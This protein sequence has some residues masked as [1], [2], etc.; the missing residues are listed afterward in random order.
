MTKLNYGAQKIAWWAHTGHFLSDCDRNTDDN[1]DN[2][3]Y[4]L[5]ASLVGH[6]RSENSIKIL[7]FA[8]WNQSL[9]TRSMDNTLEWL[10]S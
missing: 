10:N 8:L 9:N 6:N 4:K 2:K 7:D 1:Y 3:M 5:H